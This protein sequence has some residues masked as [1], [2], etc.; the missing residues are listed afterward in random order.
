LAGD[1]WFVEAFREGYLR[2]Y[3]HRDLA[4]A[5]REAG[6]LLAHGLRGRVLDLCC[7]F[8][9]HTLALREQGAD[10]LGIDL[11]PELLAHA[12]QGPGWELLRGRILRGD[13][14]A[15]PFAAASFGSVVNLFSSFGY[16]GE[17][18]DEQVL[19]EI[20]RVLAP[21]GFLAMDLMNPPFVRA[22]L[23]P[24]TRSEREGTRLVE[25]RALLE[26]GRVVA[27]DVE[28]ENESGRARWRE[29]VRLYEPH[30]LLR[31]L[32]QAGLR[33]SAAFGDFDG[34]PL[35]EASARQLI[36]AERL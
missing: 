34:S 4:A 29:E 35:S 16:F 17:A 24:F 8:G 12:A 33:R 9:R 23:V 28:L 20:A 18:G 27:K 6:F 22:R 21:G 32:E 13:A 11:S 30:E 1:P 5:R 2:L 25:S 7:G 26:G 36:L 3:P 15:L 19:L 14:R 31:R 10:V